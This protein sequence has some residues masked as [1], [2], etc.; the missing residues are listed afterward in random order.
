[1]SEWMQLDSGRP[2]KDR[3]GRAIACEDTRPVT[4]QGGPSP[5]CDERDDLG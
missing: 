5:T 2:E 3:A 1:M 4:P